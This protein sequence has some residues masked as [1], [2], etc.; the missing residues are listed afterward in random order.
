MGQIRL[1]CLEDKARHSLM[2]SFPG[3]TADPVHLNRLLKSTSG[4][5]SGTSLT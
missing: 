3:V 1:K 5:K 4:E 2:A